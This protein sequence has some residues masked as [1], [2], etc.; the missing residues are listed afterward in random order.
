MVL[1]LFR[2]QGPFALPKIT[3][4]SKVFCLFELILL[5][6]A[7]IEIKTENILKYLFILK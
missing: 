3:E 5:I 7:I 4:D 2:P 1:K 6:F